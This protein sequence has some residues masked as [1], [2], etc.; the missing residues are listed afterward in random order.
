MSVQPPTDVVLSQGVL[1]FDGRVIEAF[2]F[3]FERPYRIHV[4]QVTSVEFDGSKLRIR[5]NPR[6]VDLRV[7]LERDD[8]VKAPEVQSLID[9]IRLAL[10]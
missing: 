4:R 6:P 10:G 5:G 8:E 3:L 7:N 1:S 9:Q 2:G